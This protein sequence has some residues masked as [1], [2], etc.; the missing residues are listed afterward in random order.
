[1]MILGILLYHGFR[2]GSQQFGS[3]VILS[4][5]TLAL[6]QFLESGEVHFDAPQTLIWLVQSCLRWLNQLL[7]YQILLI[8]V[9]SLQVL[10]FLLRFSQLILQFSDCFRIFLVINIFLFL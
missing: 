3:H 2:F 4:C 5:W 1:M 8:S 9:F 7:V 10:K 6:F